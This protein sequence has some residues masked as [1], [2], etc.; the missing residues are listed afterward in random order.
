[1]SLFSELSEALRSSPLTSVEVEGSAITLIHAGLFTSKQTFRPQHFCDID[2]TNAKNDGVMLYFRG[3]LQYFIPPRH[4]L[5]NNLTESSFK[6]IGST[7]L[8]PKDWGERFAV[9]QPTEEH[10]GAMERCADDIGYSLDLVPTLAEYSEAGW[11]GLGLTVNLIATLGNEIQTFML[12]A[13]EGK[14]EHAPNI[15]ERVRALRDRCLSYCKHL[16]SM[17]TGALAEKCPLTDTD[18]YWLNRTRSFFPSKNDDVNVWNIKDYEIERTGVCKSVSDANPSEER[19]AYL[20][21]NISFG[22]EENAAL[23]KFIVCT[24]E[25]REWDTLGTTIKETVCMLKEDIEAYNGAVEETLRLKFD[26]GHPQNGVTYVQH[27]FDHNRYY[28]LNDFHGAILLR[29]QEELVRILGAVGAKSIK[30]S[31]ETGETTHSTTSSHTNIQG[32]GSSLKM[33]GN[34]SMDDKFNQ[35]ETGSRSLRLCET[36][37][38]NR[39]NERYLPDDLLFYPHEE[40]WQQIVQDALNYRQSHCEITLEY[41][42]DYAINQQHLRQMEAEVKTLL[43]SYKMGITS[44]FTRDFKRTTET[45]WH[46]EVEFFP[47]PIA[48]KA[49]GA[50]TLPAPIEANAPTETTIPRNEQIFIKRA[51][52]YI[53]NDGRLDEE[54]KADLQELA[55][56]LGIDSMRRAEII[57]ALFDE[58]EDSH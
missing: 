55:K 56:D 15:R 19:I 6:R 36:K 29:K 28:A 41:R 8:T 21:N 9:E 39:Q 23:R 54:E 13:L 51:K 33:S 22:T 4:V 16:F 46:Y 38:F 44:A 42:Q 1:M 20:T 35:E 11:M 7:A 17:Q 3:G 10:V 34:G 12:D 2:Y 49:S 24:D 18:A 40:K 48:N 5:W 52:R 14:V 57:E 30:I 53:R 37:H 58:Y 50:N 32:S 47:R 43:P 31:I 27:P 25:P 26:V 45:T